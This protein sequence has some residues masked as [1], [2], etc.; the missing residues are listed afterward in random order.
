[1][2]HRVL[3]SLLLA[4]AACVL[5][6]T[7]ASAKGATQVVLEG[8]GLD[9][10]IRLNGAPMNT[11]LPTMLIGMTGIAGSQNTSA[12]TERLGPRYVATF[13][14]TGQ[15][16]R[17]RIQLYPFAEGGPLVH[18]EREQ[19]LYGTELT[20][21]WQRADDRLDSFLVSLGA[22]APPDADLEWLTYRD[23]EH[24]LAISYPPSWQPA[25]STVAPVLVDPVIPLALGTYDFPTEGCGAVP[26]PA[27]HALGRRDAFIAVYVFRGGASWD[28]T[29]S[30]R[31]ARF[32]PELPWG[33]GPVKCADDVGG[34]IRTLNFP[35]QDVRL[36]VMTA[37]GD[38]V[39][40]RRQDQV[41]RI[42]DTLT[43]EQ[44]SSHQPPHLLPI[45]SVLTSR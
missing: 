14:F 25:R 38:D 12:P 5:L 18:T 10:P 42:L 4:T 43:V 2:K 40:A 19:T 28:A 30:E 44:R 7:A 31:P 20:S 9:R 34:T 24:G 45:H 29:V 39:S 1:V 3:V 32:G 26:G 17:I 8:P 33:E 11:D 13:T 6:P 23:Y 16:A 41:Y 21:G 36:A 35:D 37:V 27:L 15:K 22:P